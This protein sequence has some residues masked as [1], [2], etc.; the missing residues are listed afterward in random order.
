MKP[1]ILP[2]AIACNALLVGL[3]V[4]TSFRYHNEA[5]QTETILLK[6]VFHCFFDAFPWL[7]VPSYGPVGSP[8]P[9]DC[10]QDSV[11][12]GNALRCMGGPFLGM[13]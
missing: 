6:L 1:I 8:D 9:G 13:S 12:V 10:W 7:H 5:V 3:T 2:Y 4:A 11:G